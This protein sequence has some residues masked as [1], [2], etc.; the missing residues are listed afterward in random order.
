MAQLL[1]LVHLE[2]GRM[3]MPE[4]RQRLGCQHAGVRIARARAHEDPRRHLR[5]RHA[6]FNA[7]CAT[8]DAGPLAIADFGLVVRQGV[9]AGGVGRGLV[10]EN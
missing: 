2:E 6:A 7:T 8:P 4:Q 5:A 1:A 3:H 10:P 9:V